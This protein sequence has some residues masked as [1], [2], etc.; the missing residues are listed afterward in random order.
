MTS[1]AKP[2]RGKPKAGWLGRSSF[3]SEEPRPYSSR[4]RGHG[5][6][7]CATVSVVIPIYNSA[8]LL[9]GA[10]QSVLSQTY[11]HLE[12]VVVDDSSDDNTESVV[13]SFG[14]RVSYVKQ[15]NKGLPGAKSSTGLPRGRK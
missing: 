6:I 14:D 1:V 12:V 13:H 11:S 7:E 15:G 8:A 3:S 2:E 10:I 9:R 4:Q 5:V